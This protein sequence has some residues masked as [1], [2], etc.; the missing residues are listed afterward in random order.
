MPGSE[1]LV[2][3]PPSASFGFR[4]PPASCVG[5]CVCVC[6]FLC[7]GVSSVSL[8]LSKALATSVQMPTAAGSRGKRC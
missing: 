8:C 7:V 1:L 2:A 3:E 5:V 6:V 4:K